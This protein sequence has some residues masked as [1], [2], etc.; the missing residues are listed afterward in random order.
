MTN[1]SLQVC[2]S[3]FDIAVKNSKTCITG[4]FDYLNMVTAKCCAANVLFTVWQKQ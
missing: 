1:L 3:L 4:M 2:D